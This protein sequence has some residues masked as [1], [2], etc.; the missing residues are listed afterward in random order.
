MQAEN[1]LVNLFITMSPTILLLAI[2]GYIYF[3]GK[4]KNQKLVN[5]TLDTLNEYFSPIATAFV[6]ENKSAAGYT[7]GLTLKKP[8][9]DDENDP[10]RFIQRMR[11]HFSLEDRQ[12][13]VAFFKLLIKKPKD[14]FIIEGDPNVRND[15]FK[16]EIADI[17]SF[18]RWD[19]E[20]IQGEW[21]DLSDYEPT[22]TFSQK[23]FHKTNYPRAL[24]QLYENEPDLK[25]LMYNLSGLFRVS[26]KRKE[27]WTFRIALVINPKDKKQ[28]AIARET[29]LR[30]L[31][32]LHNM[33]IA[34]S[35]QPKRF[36]G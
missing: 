29:A 10:L 17:S 30:F 34:I 4:N 3:S 33:N 13:F 14:Y 24:K 9:K 11:I 35:K 1:I 16:V 32:G 15:H 25:K 8:T 22:S 31:R 20:K 28:F 12:N 36:I 19:L 21:E 2:V 5:K 18:G 6:E 26:I 7:Y 27:D 23:F